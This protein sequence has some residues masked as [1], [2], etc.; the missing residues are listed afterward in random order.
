MESPPPRDVTEV[1][2]PQAPSVRLCVGV[3]GHR[4]TNPAYAAHET[5]IADHLSA[6]FDILDAVAKAEPVIAAREA[7]APTRLHSML[8]DGFD[9]MAGHQAL[10]RGWELVAPL[11][12]G[13]ALNT[14]V[15]AAPRSPTEARFLLAGEGD[16]GPETRARAA[17]I[18][19]LQAHARLFELADQD[20]ALSGLFLAQLEA[21]ADMSRA[22]AY[23]VHA[24]EQVALA[25]RVMIEQSDLIVGVWDGASISHVGGA[26]HTLAL[27]LEM[28]APVVWID[29]RAPERWMILTAPE[30]LAAI[31]AGEPIHP[32]REEALTDL[33][34]AALRPRAGRTAGKAT[35]LHGHEALDR[36]RWR[37]RSV[38]VW[39]AYRRVEAL[40]GAQGLAGKLRDLTQTYESPLDIADGGAA[41]LMARAAALPGQDRAFVGRI[42]AEVLSRFAWADGIS[43]RLSDAY[44]GGMILSFA[45]SACAIVGGLAYIP[46]ARHGDKWAFALIELGLLLGILLITFIGRKRGWHKRWFETRRVAEY[47]RHAPIL[48]LLGVSRPTGRWP[49][50]SETSWPEWYARHA[51]RDVGL[52]RAPMTG[53]YLR[54]AL[55]GL[56]LEHVTTQRDYHREKAL[57]L[58]R[59]HHELDRVSSALFSLAVLGVALYLTLKGAAAL[60]LLSPDVVEHLANL[61]TFLGVAL[62]T[63]GGGVAGM[64]YFGDFERFSAISEVTAEKLDA[65]ASRIRLLLKAPEG[66]LTYGRVS[67]LAHV[68]D[69]IVVAEIENWQA[70]FGGKHITVPA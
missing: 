53:A 67:E 50:G 62:P 20:A 59:A 3:T 29:A 13:R 11:P 26:G 64:R 32:Q 15:N 70:V 39:H 44:R 46:F 51:L 2:A 40:F 33:A 8:V 35:V 14:A 38:S 37:P 61:F 63:F 54:A 45:F 56:L 4:R 65:V 47:F 41:S 24:S 60:G 30:S 58:A 25:A 49:R 69:D 43:A 6:I 12:F 27:A 1:V 48:L 42:G 5:E 57:R 18:A 34:R 9:Q 17:A 31:L 23:A 7:R 52:P 16:C 36:E 68:T 28:G 21:P 10:A 19:D 55:E 66:A 22:Q